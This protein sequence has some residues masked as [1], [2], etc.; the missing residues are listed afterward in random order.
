M[1][2]RAT[3][4]GLFI[5]VATIAGV[6]AA[7]QVATAPQSLAKWMP[8]GALLYLESS[9]FAT[10]LR[11][12]DRSDVQ[13]RWLASKNHEQFMTTRLALKLQDVYKEFSSAAGFAPDLT[14]LQTFAGTDSALAV[15][16]IGRL[17]LVYISR[18]PAAQLAQ[19]ALITARSGYRSRT[20]AGPSHLV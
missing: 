4:L 6:W 18:L 10:Q 15:Y 2:K 14:A 8:G 13:T 12:W 17:D 5:G 16:D 7:A 19:N 20:A 3:I 11:D 1:M 9:D